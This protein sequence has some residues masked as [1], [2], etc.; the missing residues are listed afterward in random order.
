M[1]GEDELTQAQLAAVMAAILKVTGA[2]LI[3]EIGTV[4]KEQW[5]EAFEI[6]GVPWKD[7][8]KKTN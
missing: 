1:T 5:R 8:S 3:T 7:E 2:S 6:A 4:T